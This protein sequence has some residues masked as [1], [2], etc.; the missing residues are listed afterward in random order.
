VECRCT[1]L[2]EFFGREAEEYAAGHLEAESGDPARLFVCADTGRR[3][4][5]AY[6]ED[7][8]ARLT[9]AQR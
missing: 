9:Q 3:W 5:L 4:E 7:G 6:D 1:D 8:Q 2:T